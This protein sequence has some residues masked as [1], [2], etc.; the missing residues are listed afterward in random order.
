MACNQCGFMQAATSS[1][2]TLSWM[3]QNWPWLVG[4]AVVV[5]G[6]AVLA[7]SSKCP[8]SYDEYVGAVQ[9]GDAQG[10]ARAI[11]AGQKKGCDWVRKVRR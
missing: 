11:S 9:A 10:R 7:S 2:E 8:D 1:P 3:D 6:I 4:G 5:V